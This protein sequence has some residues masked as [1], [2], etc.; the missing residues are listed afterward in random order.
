MKMLRA[1]L[2]W[3]LLFLADLLGWFPTI[4]DKP[5]DKE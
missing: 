4:P 1:L 3:P 2:L 5:D